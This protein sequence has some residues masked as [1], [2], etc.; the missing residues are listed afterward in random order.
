M[1]LQLGKTSEITCKQL[2][3][4]S[5]ERNEFTFAIDTEL[6]DKRE[7]A[8]SVRDLGN[9]NYE[10]MQHIVYL[11]PYFNFSEELRNYL[12]KY[13]PSNM[14]RL[15]G[16]HFAENRNKFYLFKSIPYAA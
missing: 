6:A 15:N 3:F 12:K 7:G 8:F 14:D 5:A 4:E 13:L 9:G 11:K 1:G 16:I 2:F 10:I